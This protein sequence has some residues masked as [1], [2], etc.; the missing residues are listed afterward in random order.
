VKEFIEKEKHLPN[1]PSEE[2]IKEE[3]I[4]LAEMN[5][6]LME[7]I[8]ELMLYTIQQQKDIEALKLEMSQLKK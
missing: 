3:G 5:V 7:K 8:E 4:D 1:I 2:E 6:K